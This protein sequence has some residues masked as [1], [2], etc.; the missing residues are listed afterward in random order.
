MAVKTK[1]PLKIIIAGEQ[2]PKLFRRKNSATDALMANPDVMHGAL[3]LGGTRIPLT[4]LLDELIAGST[5]DDFVE[6]HPSVSGGDVQ[7]ALHQLREWVE[8]K[9]FLNDGN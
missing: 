6:G 9:E 4:T 5:I 7:A 2:E 8:E 3:V 1:P